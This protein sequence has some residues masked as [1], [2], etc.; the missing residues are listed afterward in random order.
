[1]SAVHK[2]IHRVA[3]RM[4]L[5][6]RSPL[7]AY[8]GFAP[9]TA[10]VPQLYGQFGNDVSLAWPHAKIGDYRLDPHI[11]F[12]ICHAPQ[13]VMLPGTNFTLFNGGYLL[14]VRGK[15]DGCPVD[16]RYNL[17]VFPRII[18]IENFVDLF[19]GLDSDGRQKEVDV[20]NKTLPHCLFKEKEAFF[21]IPALMLLAR[22][23]EDGFKIDPNTINR[24]ALCSVVYNAERSTV[25]NNTTCR[26][27]FETPVEVITHST[28]EGASGSTQT[29][30]RQPERMSKIVK[31]YVAGLGFATD[32]V[33]ELEARLNACIDPCSFSLDEKS[34]R[35]LIDPYFRLEFG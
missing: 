34:L 17:R 14:E 11:G 32:N 23:G 21:Y 10:H 12:E 26:H 4:S 7:H 18:G 9:G 25:K 3:T 29:L 33:G 19:D 5:D 35:Q 13:T 30:D 16:A 28:S 8:F 15:T 1:M 22:I 31:S 27:Y 2:E 6:G 24:G 20:L